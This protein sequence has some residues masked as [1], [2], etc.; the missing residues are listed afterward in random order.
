MIFF[1][2]YDKKQYFDKETLREAVQDAVKILNQTKKATIKAMFSS[3][4]S[5]CLEVIDKQGDAISY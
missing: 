1:I 2:V 5:R 4:G 3:Y